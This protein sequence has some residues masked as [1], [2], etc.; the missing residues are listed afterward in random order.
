MILATLAQKFQSGR[1]YRLSIRELQQLSDRELSDLGIM[2]S[3]IE[4][5]ARIAAS[6]A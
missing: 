5:V 6:A 2:R 3:D 4:S 1:R